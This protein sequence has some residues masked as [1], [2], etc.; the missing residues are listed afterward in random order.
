M[1]SDGHTDPK[2]LPLFGKDS[3]RHAMRNRDANWLVK[4]INKLLNLIVKPGAKNELIVSD[5]NAILTL[6]IQALTAGSS[7]LH[8][9][10]MSVASDYYV[11]RTWDALNLVEGDTDMYVARPWEHRNS[12]TSERINGTIH[13]YSYTSTTQ[14][15]SD[16]G[17]TTETQYITPAILLSDV[18]QPNPTVITAI[19][20]PSGV[21]VSS[22]QLT[23]LDINVGGRA[24]ATPPA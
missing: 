5:G 24:W 17:T 13:N 20:S 1:K 4:A 14:R 7:V 19:R 23:L 22:E 8:F 6:N 12:I 10:V 3:G 16:N 21:E 2:N 9:R 18:S 11:C 15:E